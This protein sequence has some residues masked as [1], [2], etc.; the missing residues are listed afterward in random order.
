MGK[1]PAKDN[2]VIDK[3]MAL[4]DRSIGAASCL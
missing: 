1:E 4:F 3:A 2:V